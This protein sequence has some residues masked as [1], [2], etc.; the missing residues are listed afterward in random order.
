MTRVQGEPFGGRRGRAG[1]KKMCELLGVDPD[2]AASVTATMSGGSDVVEVT[3]ERMPIR[4]RMSMEEWAAIGRAV[5]E[6]DR[7]ADSGRGW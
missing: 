2:D 3:V 7:E 5:R 6:A 1:N 4:R